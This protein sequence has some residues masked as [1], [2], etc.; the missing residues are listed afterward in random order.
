MGFL[1]CA[2]VSA[3]R[4]RLT[5]QDTHTAAVLRGI[6]AVDQN[7]AW[8]SGTGGTFLRT[9]NGGIR[10]TA[11]TVPGAD[12]LDFRDVQAFNSH[13]AV[14]MSAGPGSASRIYRTED[15]GATWN[16]TLQNA[17]ASGFFDAIAF[18]NSREG[19]LLGD[20]VDG[21]FTLYRTPDGGVTWTRI[22]PSSLPRSHSGEGAFA[23]SGTCL[24]V[25]G[26]GVA[27]FGTGG[28]AGG[29][30]FRSTDRG[31]TWQAVETPIRHDSDSS[32]IFSLAF[33]DRL[34]GIAVGGDYGRPA[35]TS[36]NTLVTEDGGVTWRTV[37]SGPSGYRSVVAFA[38]AGRSVAA[39][40]TGIDYSLDGGTTWSHLSDEGHHAASLS[41]N[42]GFL[43][44]DHGRTTRIVV[45]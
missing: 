39:G 2:A 34:H 37:K 27:W 32:G 40:P 11:A 42:V 24:A 6:S 26:G 45:R 23:A 1:L 15:G 31:K 9:Q 7:I 41:G 36:G 29:R 44:G 21:A 16:P 4:F 33:R 12:K 18:W 19:L 17:D 20:P 35:E 10:W 3:P 5:P 38:K 28:T 13:T 30:V 8:A 25:L 14:L 22:A 43:T